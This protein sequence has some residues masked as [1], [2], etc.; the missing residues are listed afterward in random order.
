[1]VLGVA[2]ARVLGAVGLDHN[3]SR[4]GAAPGP[5]C[6][7]RQQ[8]EGPLRRA[9]VREVEPQVR[10]DH[11]H[12]RH[13]GEVVPLGD[14]L[15][16]H[17]EIDLA[18]AH[19][20]QD[21]AQAASGV[22]VQPRHARLWEALQQPLLHLLCAHPHPLHGVGGAVWTALRHGGAVPTVVAGQAPPADAVVGQRDG[23]V[24]A[25]KD[26]AAGFA[27]HRGGEAAAVEKE[28]RLIA[29]LQDPGD[30]L[31]QRRAE[32]ALRPGLVAAEIDDL[33][34]GQGPGGHTLGEL[35]Q[36]QAPAGDA[37]VALQR[38]RRGPQHRHG[39]SALGAH[40]RQ[41][42]SMVADPLL[43]LE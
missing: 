25:G 38:G 11:A 21:R 30:A 19:L 14:H 29:A 3:V 9:E 26:L 35:Q 12:Q 8:L 5:S 28:D 7:L 32:E 33:H 37:V 42:P 18:A 17:E 1:M 2:Q 31:G 36:L 13:V 40:Q 10:A 15:R 41:I 6:D 27:E 34:L 39:A 23:A 16:P 22:A 43:L 4:A 24:L 20:G